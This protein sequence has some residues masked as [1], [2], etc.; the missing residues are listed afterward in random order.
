[1]IYVFHHDIFKVHFMML[2]LV[3]HLRRLLLFLLRRLLLV[4]A[5][6]NQDLLLGLSSHCS[7]LL[8]DLR[9][10]NSCGKLPSLLL[11][12]SLRGKRSDRRRDGALLV[13]D[14]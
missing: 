13:V 2:L 14:S 4:H 11:P 5:A 6:L 3:L 10:L 8:R 1:M 7:D 9:K 12:R